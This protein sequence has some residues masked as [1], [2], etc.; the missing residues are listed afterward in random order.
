MCF[1]LTLTLMVLRADLDWPW[2]FCEKTLTQKCSC[3]DHDLDGF[4]CTDLVPDGL[5][6]DLDPDGFLAELGLVEMFHC[7]LRLAL[8]LEVLKN[9]NKTSLLNVRRLIS[10][11]SCTVNGILFFS[12]TCTVYRKGWHI[13]LQIFP[14][15]KTIM[16]EENISFVMGHPSSANVVSMGL[17]VCTWVLHVCVCTCLCVRVLTTKPKSRTLSHST[18]VPNASN[19][20]LRSSFL[21]ESSKFPTNSLFCGSGSRGGSGL[22]S[23]YGSYLQTG[24]HYKQIR[25]FVRI[26]LNTY[27]LTLVPNVRSLFSTLGILC[28]LYKTNDDVTWNYR[29][30]SA[31]RHM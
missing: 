16:K 4:M 20:F 28:P 25:A 27:F 8:L 9:N 21:T 10:T 23:P 15:K 11:V 2:R 26:P 19:S 22:A 3:T 13:I 29:S 5:C 17:S 6:T 14:K 31:Q 1:V 24:I 7:R 18:T 30:K 12:V